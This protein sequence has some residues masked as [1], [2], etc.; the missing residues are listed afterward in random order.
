[1]PEGD[2]IFRAAR[3]LHRAL[4]GRTVTRFESVFP[5]L[6]RIDDDVPLR[7]RTIERVEAR[8]KH[9]LIWFSGPL[10]LRTHMRMHGSW[11]IY[12]PHERWRRP[13]H[14]MRIVLETDEI[15]AVAFDVPVAEFA[16]SD[17]LERTPQL[18]ALGPD[19]LAEGF[20]AE[21]AARRISARG[22]AEIAD[23]LLD[24]TAIAGIGNVY[25]SEVLFASRVNPFEKVRALQPEEVDRLV[26]TAVKFMR[27]N[28]AEGAPAAIETYRG[29]RR[30]TG[31]YDPGARL[32]VYGRAGK[33]CRVCGRPISRRRQ[34]PHARST[35]WC[36][37]CQPAKDSGD[38]LASGFSPQK[39]H[40]P[41]GR[42]R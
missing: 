33:P 8:G 29:L 6:S 1:V 20:T 11:H 42:T 2:T 13:H 18:R 9:L 17:A 12:R 40:A 10:V 19:P 4:A 16:T 26:A 14:S 37:R 38:V 25:K 3:T 7:G 30:T 27:A 32:W 34:G 24:Q 39:N 28:V 41:P 36:A 35:Y 31:R 5:S 22:D 21:E 23:V 15:H